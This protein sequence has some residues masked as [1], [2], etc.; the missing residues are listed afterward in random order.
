LASNL[1][2]NIPITNDDSDFLPGLKY[3][4]LSD[5]RLSEWGAIDALARWCSS[6]ENLVIKGNTLVAGDESGKQTRP[7]VI[8]RIPSLTTL[9]GASISSR[10]R[11]DS[12]LFYISSIMHTGVASDEVRSQQHPRWAELCAKYGRPDEVRNVQKVQNKLSNQ[13]IDL[14]LH[15]YVQTMKQRSDA[16]AE[17]PEAVLRVLPT[18]LLAANGQRRPHRA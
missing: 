4:S 9:D 7:L 16:L 5:N 12:E 6:L 17:P 11:T 14:K 10:E 3:L 18:N 1:I 8:A 13:L 15:R 2:E